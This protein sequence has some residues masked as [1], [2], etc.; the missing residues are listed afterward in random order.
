MSDEQVKRAVDTVVRSLAT[1]AKTLRLYP[2]SSPIPRQTAEAA[3]E[4]L[5]SFLVD[6][7][8]LTL[9]VAREGF[10]FRNSAV[11]APGSSELADMLTR[12]GVAEMSVL[13]GAG[14]DE[15]ISFVSAVLRDPLEVREAGG[16]G[17]VLAAG[18]VECVRVSDVSLTVAELEPLD[19]GDDIDE[20]LRELASDPDK[21]A[22]WLASATSGDPA[23]LAEGLTELAGAVGAE[24]MDRL[25]ASLSSAFLKQQPDGRDALMGVSVK[26]TDIR[27]LMSGVFGSI[28]T[29]DMAQS[30]AGG[31]FGKNV[32]SM[33]NMLAK[34][35]LGERV[36]EILAE[37]KPLLASAG[38]TAR[39]MAFLD[40]MLELREKA[41]PESPLVEQRPDYT[42][43]AQIAEVRP[44]EVEKARGEV[45][46]SMT[47]MNTRSVTTML[48]LL[49]QQEDFAL[50]CKTLDGLASMVPALFEMRDFRLADQVL[51]E[52]ASREARTDQPWPE[53]T[54]KLRGAI[55][56][57][58]GPRSM[59]A[60]LHALSDDPSL[61][62]A[63]RD[64]LRRTGAP[65][66][67]AFLHEALNVR[68][69]DGLAIAG[70]ALG[71]RLLDLLVAEAPH[72][73]W[74]NLAPIVQRLA[75]EGDPRS[76][77][78]VDA[79]LRRPDEQSR[80]E[81][82]K[83]LAGAG[84][85]MAVRQLASLTRDPSPE[86]ALV[87]IRAAGRSVAPGSASMLGAR[88][89]ELDCDGKDFTA[90]R[91]IINALA[92]SADPEASDVLSRIARRKALIKR[93]HFAEIND[94][95]G[96]ALRARNA[97]GDR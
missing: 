12:H 65:A 77:Q 2:P 80:Q 26:D 63:A 15:L 79:I 41:E 4:A 20:F 66:Q 74:F 8:V 97:G 84:T 68:D 90:C 54:E 6:E 47:K 36:S 13:P 25:M 10:S 44:E 9:T 43:V 40:H 76:S 59:S 34:L 22:L 70:D 35:P 28:G 27:S 86:V 33:S 55:R 31:M 7:P 75:T 23:A 52:L 62:P 48:Q 89:D 29:Q 3:L 91:E 32:L 45:Q 93:G 5:N 83:G 50:Y 51:S 73:Q 71:R 57:A 46:S 64:T 85:A 18:G 19:Q 39:E 61:M 60:L 17:A 53:L 67:T 1:S 58:T 92:R 49:D 72:A 56:K 24:G 82:A 30:L 95:A 88:F 94:L 87:A 42:K 21:L 78:T 81:A 37:V 14:V 38:H 96:Q 11:N 69:S 16:M